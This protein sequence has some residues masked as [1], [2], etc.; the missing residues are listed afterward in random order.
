[1]QKIYEIYSINLFDKTKNALHE[2]L[3]S[4]DEKEIAK[5]CVK[6]GQF[7]SSAIRD[8]Y[9]FKPVNFEINEDTDEIYIVHNLY[10]TEVNDYDME[11]RKLRSISFAKCEK[12]RLHD[13]VNKFNKASDTYELQTEK[14]KVLS[15]DET[16]DAF[17][18]KLK[19]LNI[20]YRISKDTINETNEN[21]LEM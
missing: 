2:Y 13:I 12:N 18:E 6:M 16:Y 14:T 19:A 5:L 17:N 3:I 9:D 15:V 8:V 20:N 21:V 10:K 7:T 11:Y 1:M 4:G